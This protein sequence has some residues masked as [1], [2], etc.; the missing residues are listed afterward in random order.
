MRG[1]RRT[2]LSFTL[3]ADDRR[4]GQIVR[5]NAPR[6]IARIYF[7]LTL[8]S[9]SLCIELDDTM[10]AAFEGF[11]AQGLSHEERRARDRRPL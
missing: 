6:C 2:A 10:K 1:S 4:V 8:N 3:I 11:D 7:S 9:V 5:H